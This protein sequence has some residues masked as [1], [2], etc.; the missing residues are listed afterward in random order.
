[1]VKIV[2]G[3][4]LLAVWFLGRRAGFVDAQGQFEGH[5]MWLRYVLEPLPGFV[6]ASAA[7]WSVGRY[8]W[9]SLWQF[10]QFPSAKYWV[11]AALFPAGLRCLVSTAMYTHARI[12]WAIHGFGRL[13]VPSINSYF[14]VPA[15]STF[16]EY[17]PAAFFEEVVWRGFLMPRF[18]SRYGLYRGLLFVSA[19]W[20]AYHLQADFSGHTSDGSFMF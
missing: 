3:L 20:G 5:V 10:L 11:L 7:A 19:A 15:A 12:A 4:P 6:L 9:K 13:L 14:G 16:A 17:I 2:A 18:I 1:M 8:R